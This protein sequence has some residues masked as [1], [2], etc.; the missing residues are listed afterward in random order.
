MSN[1]NVIST[2]DSETTLKLEALALRLGLTFDA[3]IQEILN[4]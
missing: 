1:V 2:L 3:L 4:G